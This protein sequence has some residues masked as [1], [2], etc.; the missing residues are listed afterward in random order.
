MVTINVE[1]N[2]YRCSLNSPQVE[3]NKIAMEPPYNS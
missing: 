2:N 3:Q 1:Y